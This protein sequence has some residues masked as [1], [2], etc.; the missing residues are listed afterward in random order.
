M[1]MHLPGRCVGRRT[2]GYQCRSSGVHHPCDVPL[3]ELHYAGMYEYFRGAAPLIRVVKVPD[4]VGPVVYYAGDPPSQLV[5]IGTSTRL[6]PRLAALRQRRPQLVLLAAEP[7][8][9][10]LERTRHA[11][12]RELRQPIRRDVEW[13]RKDSRLMEHITL[14]R[15]EFGD[16]LA[17]AG[18][19]PP[20]P[21]HRMRRQ[22]SPR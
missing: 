21:W 16:P 18:V 8:Y 11:Q 2:D 17:L 4:E 5:K 15:R 19:E 20:A 14:I 22:R 12:F 3:C 7:G 1:K 9:Y 13:Y 10:D 6:G